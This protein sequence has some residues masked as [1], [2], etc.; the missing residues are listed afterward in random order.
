MIIRTF[1][2]LANSADISSILLLRSFKLE[3]LKDNFI[4]GLSAYSFH[5]PKFMFYNS[6]K[7]RHKFY[8]INEIIIVLTLY[9]K[10]RN[11]RET[12]IS[13]LKIIPL[14]TTY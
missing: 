2:I 12:P 9:I 14:Q 3:Y 10:Y 11:L 6:R 4:E 8:S 5:L 1:S 13:V 7:T